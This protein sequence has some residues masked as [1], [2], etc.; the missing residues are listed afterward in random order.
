MPNWCSNQLT[1]TGPTA[2]LNALLATV[3]GTGAGETFSLAEA[4]PQ[5]VAADADW[6]E[7]QVQWRGTKWDVRAVEDDLAPKA[8]RCW[9]S[10][11]TAWSP[12]TATIAYLSA[13]FPELRFEIEYAEHGNQVFGTEVF[14]AGTM[15]EAIDREASY[16]ED[17]EL[18]E[19][20]LVE[21]A[22][23]IDAARTA[24]Q[25]LVAREPA[26]A[27]TGKLFTDLNRHLGDDQ[28]WQVADLLLA[29]VDPSKLPRLAVETV[30]TGRPVTIVTF[31]R[32]H[33][34]PQMRRVG[35]TLYALAPRLARPNPFGP[36]ATDTATPEDEV[37]R[38]TALVTGNGLTEATLHA[39]APYYDGSLAE[40]L[41][42]AE[43]LA[44]EQAPS[45]TPLNAATSPESGELLVSRRSA[46]TGV[47]HRQG[48]ARG[49]LRR[50]DQ[51]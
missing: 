4:L 2:T 39:I 31:L 29:P 16:D 20:E 42:A 7:W 49:V 18:A 34:D 48:D 46:A 36:A 27:R 28:M 26:H 11:S 33:P 8:G 19:P 6:F 45:G 38:L 51:G 5:P 15:V 41:D 32:A 37:D 40:L 23:D 12:P 44:G 35:D 43:R 14:C 21:T 13:R 24:L 30:L 3:R 9:W 47:S 1:V 17:D 25:T 22:V 10:F 50:Q